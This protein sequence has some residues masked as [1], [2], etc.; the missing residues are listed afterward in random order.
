MRILYSYEDN[1]EEAKE[2]YLKS[3][4]NFHVPVGLRHRIYAMEESEVYEFS[5]QHFDED[6][7]R[8]EKGD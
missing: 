5:T 3:G 8:L 2:V 7:I 6:S 4:Q 1:L